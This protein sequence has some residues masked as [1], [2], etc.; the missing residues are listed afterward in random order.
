MEITREFAEIVARSP[1]VTPP[2][3]LAWHPI[4][5]LSPMVAPPGTPAA[6]AERVNA[7]VVANLK[8]PDVAES[9]AKL[10]LE[11]MIGSPADATAFFAEETRLWS[12]VI[13]AAHIKVE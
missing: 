13:T 12:K 11:P 5:T 8:R 3:M 9:L 4:K 1:M 2:M 10:T 6:I 7:D